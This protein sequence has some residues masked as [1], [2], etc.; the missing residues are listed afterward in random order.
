MSTP[1]PFPPDIL[2]RARSLFPHTTQGKLF[3][4][5][6]GTS[7]LSTRVLAAMHAYLRE[8][9]E[10]K[11]DTYRDDLV[12][13]TELRS[14]I[15]QLI[16]AESVTRIALT[17]NTTDAINV[18]ATGLE[19]KQGDRVLVGHTEFPAN[20]WPFLN[21][22]NWGVEVDLIQSTDGRVTFEQIKH[23]IQPRTRLVALSTV[24]FLSGYRA[25]M[26][27][28]GEMCRR[29]GITFAVDGAQAVGGIVV[30]VQKLQIDAL[31]AGGQKWQMSPH[32]TGFIYVS[33]MLQTQIRQKNLGWLSVA[34]PWDFHNY[35][36]EIDATA[37]RYESGSLIMPS[38]WGMHAALGT[39]LEF[40]PPAIESHILAITRILMEGFRSIDGISVYT[41]SDDN[42]RA[43]IVTIT[44]PAKADVAALIQRLQQRK[45]TVAPHEG[46]LRFSPHFYNSSE[47]MDA[48]VAIL[49]EVLHG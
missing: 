23:A 44:P 16:N 34:N 26:A 11:L 35:T 22:R 12:M 19:W 20:V 2:A 39:L 48:T 41:P 10:G 15:K 38:L 46:K 6:A 17:A 49:R 3:L 8:R 25:D 14:H 4:N 5:H 42:E 18:V 27:A 30:D 36:Q 43:G 31:S 21:L 1:K 28:I 37:R 9:S 7:P 32:G 33:E 47:E 40:G 29:K 24:Q 13:V 45:V